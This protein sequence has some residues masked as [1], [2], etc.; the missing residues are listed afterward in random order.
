MANNRLT[1]YSSSF[2]SEYIHC[3]VLSGTTLSPR[4]AF[5]VI[6]NL[7]S[8]SQLQKELEDKSHPP[9]TKIREKKKTSEARQEEQI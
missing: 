6:T 5:S 8:T 3:T 9:D 4:L 2:E 1:T 7:I